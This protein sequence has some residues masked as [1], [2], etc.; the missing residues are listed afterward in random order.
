M[1]RFYGS[2]VRADDCFHLWYYGCYGA[3]RGDIG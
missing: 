2:V 3:D 1:V